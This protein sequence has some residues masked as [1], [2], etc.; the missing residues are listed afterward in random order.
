MA[1][2]LG[3][4]EYLIDL[5]TGGNQ[6]ISTQGGANIFS[7]GDTTVDKKRKN[8][9]KNYQLTLSFTWGAKLLIFV[10]K[11]VIYGYREHLK[12]Q[13]K[14]VLAKISWNTVLNTNE[15]K[16]GRIKICT[17]KKLEFALVSEY[18]SFDL[19]EPD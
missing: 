13:G 14:Y 5:S 11:W 9:R 12:R 17:K 1:V 18:T 15:H 7:L 2:F 19:E 16:L 3:V 10:A 8:L 6:V 4:W